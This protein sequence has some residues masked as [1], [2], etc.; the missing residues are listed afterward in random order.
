[1]ADSK[2]VR[3][4]I[5]ALAAMAL[6]DAESKNY[7]IE[8]VCYEL[9]RKARRHTVHPMKAPELRAAYSRAY[10]L[11]HNSGNNYYYH[12][13]L[14]AALFEEI[15]VDGILIQVGRMLHRDTRW[16]RPLAEW[17]REQAP[18]LGLEVPWITDDDLPA[19]KI[20]ELLYIKQIE[21]ERSERRAERIRQAKE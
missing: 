8:P 2:R 4:F 21:K 20:R 18:K 3:R 15:N 12:A 16:S 6:K 7:L 1:M 11:F 5:A 13:L 10:Y 14:K 9:L 19:W 17:A